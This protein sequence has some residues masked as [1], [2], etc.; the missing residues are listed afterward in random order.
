MS[1]K[2][3]GFTDDKTKY[4]FGECSVSALITDA[5]SLQSYQFPTLHIFL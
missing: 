2:K 3:V 5:S 1:K 4:N